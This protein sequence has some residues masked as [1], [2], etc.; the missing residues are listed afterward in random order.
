MLYCRKAAARRLPFA[1]PAIGAVG[2]LLAGCSF[3]DSGVSTEPAL[4]ID[5]GPSEGGPLPEAGPA[6]DATIADSSTV[7]AAVDVTVAADTGA[8]VAVIDDSGLPVDAVADAIA[9]PDTSIPDTGVVA[10][11]GID[12]AAPA[13]AGD[14]GIDAGYVY[15]DMGALS[16][17]GADAGTNTTAWVHLPAAAGG[18]STTAYSV[19]LWFKTTVSEG[20]MFEVYDEAGGA[21]RFLSLNT[22]TVC[23]YVY[24]ANGEPQVCSTARY[25]DGAWH[26]A[27]GTLGSDGLNVYVDG[28]LAASST[29][30]TMS[31]FGAGSEFRLGMGHQYFV[32]PIVYFSG[33]LDEVRLWSVERSAIDIATY[34]AQSIDPATPGLQGYWHLDETGTAST[35]ADATGNGNDG[36]LM[37]FTYDPSPWVQPGAF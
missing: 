25:D 32:S 9:L 19:E 23:F 33:E 24:A 29:A 4:F 2:L 30:A 22:G 7:D 21:D 14:A 13:D 17:A 12:G 1:C 36:T 27:A 6:P 15:T 34:Y 3:D 20:N 11:A 18:A 37:N 10:E 26:H 16:F 8:D 31:A 5:G 28:V 35:T